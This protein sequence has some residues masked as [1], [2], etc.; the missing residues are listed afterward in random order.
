MIGSRRAT[1][2]SLAS[3]PL[4][5]RS[6][7][8]VKAIPVSPDQRAGKPMSQMGMVGCRSKRTGDQQENLENMGRLVRRQEGSKSKR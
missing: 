2:L 6:L 5:N 1:I 7:E 4:P 3:L 8:C